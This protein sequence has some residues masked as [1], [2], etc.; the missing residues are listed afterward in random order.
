MDFIGKL[1]AKNTFG[2]FESGKNN[3]IV[4]IICG[5]LLIILIIVLIVCLVKKD[6]KFSNQKENDGEETHMYHVVNSGCPFS[7]KMSELLAQNNNMIGG[8]KVKD[9]TMEHPLTKKFN[10]SGTP[11]ILCTK[12]NKS[13]VGFK[14]LDKVLE[15]LRPDNN[16]N[17]NKDNNSSGKDILLVGSM[18]CG[19]C[20]KAK[21]L[22]EELGLDYE[23]VESNSPHGVQR[24]KDSNANGV[25]L[26]LQLSTNKTINGFNQEEIR[27]LKN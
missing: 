24:M 11:T 21:V 27:K 23:F 3:N 14:P 22:M 7:R 25:P 2:M 5:V 19:F 15:D 4:N 26:I 1:N 9:I 17:G 8:A 10:V 13:S 18:Q 6:D 20:K 16:K 12:S